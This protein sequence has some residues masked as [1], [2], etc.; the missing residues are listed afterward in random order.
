MTNIS[1]I[2]VSVPIALQK[3]IIANNELLRQYQQK[4]VGEI[5]EANYQMMQ[6]LRLDPDAGWKL[7]IERMVYVRPKTEEE[8]PTE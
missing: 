1:E 7:D 6:L 4:L 3:L 5:E 2:T 8:Q